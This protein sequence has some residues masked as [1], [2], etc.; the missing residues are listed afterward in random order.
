M[1]L[2]KYIDNPRTITQVGNI[3]TASRTKSL[4]LTDHNF[5]EVYKAINCIMLLGQCCLKEI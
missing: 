1:Y 4:I 3:D 2:A 5:H